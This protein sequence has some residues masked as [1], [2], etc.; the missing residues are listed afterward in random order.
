M[1]YYPFSSQ[2]PKPSHPLTYTTPPHKK[3]PHKRPI[4]SNPWCA[5]MEV[6]MSLLCT[7]WRRSWTMRWIRVMR[8]KIIWRW[9]G[10]WVWR[11][12]GLFSMILRL[13]KSQAAGKKSSATASPKASSPQSSSTRKSTKTTSH[14]LAQKVHLNSV[15]SNWTGFWL[16]WELLELMMTWKCKN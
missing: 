8:G 6:I 2:S 3:T 7:I 16:K 11:R 1:K 9:I 13:F 10:S 5:I 4:F 12:S 14:W 15:A